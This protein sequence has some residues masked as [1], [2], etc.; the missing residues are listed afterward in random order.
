MRRLVL[1]IG[2]SLLL[3]VGLMLTLESA[4]PARAVSL[5]VCSTC[6]FQTIQAAIDAASPGFTIR[7]AQGVYTENLTV[8]KPVTLEGGYEPVGWVRSLVD[9]E[10]IIDGGKNGTVVKFVEGSDDSVLDGFTVQNGKAKRGGGV[11][12]GGTQVTIRSCTVVG[13]SAQEVGGGVMI[14]WGSKA[15]VQ[16][17]QILSNTSHDWFGSG[18]AIVLAEVLVDSNLIAYNASGKDM[19]GKG[20]IGIAMDG[21]SQPVTVTN[22]VIVGN[23][24]KGITVSDGVYDL[25]IVNNTIASNRNEGVLAWG[26]IV[27][28]LLRNNVIALNGYCG[29]AAASGAELQTIDYNDVWKNGGGEGNYC[30]YGGAVKPPVAGPGSISVD[31]LFISTVN[32]DYHLQLE[33]PCVDAGTSEAAP[34]V[35]FEGDPRPD[36]CGI[37]IGAD[38]YQGGRGCYRVYLP[39]VQR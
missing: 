7:V 27:V 38:E 35:D 5:D 15:I 21:P 22:N 14:A 23:T 36:G 13:N 9:Y 34:S 32:G 26:T 29:I 3:V 30:D 20:A 2:F 18:L 37:D 33:S 24:D 10:T 11:F 6:D 28:P 16:S 12:V 17:N 4:Q 19:N 1:V 25:Q 31:P 8:G 39:L